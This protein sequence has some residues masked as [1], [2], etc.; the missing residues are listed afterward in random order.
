MKHNRKLRKRYWLVLYMTGLLIFTVSS[1]L[2]HEL[3]D[4]QLGFCEGISIVLILVGFV[5]FCSF[6]LR[7]EN[8]FRL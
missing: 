2:R 3:S 6:L 1:M 4:F 7:K 5:L 8:P